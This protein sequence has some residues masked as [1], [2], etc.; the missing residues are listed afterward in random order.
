M[1]GIPLQQQ[2]LL[3]PLK[4]KDLQCRAGCCRQCY[5]FYNRHTILPIE[6]I[7]GPDLDLEKIFNLPR[8]IGYNRS[9]FEEA[10][11][12]LWQD[13]PT[14]QSIMV[15]TPGTYSVEASNNGEC[16]STES[17][18]VAL[19]P[20]VLDLGENIVLVKMRHQLI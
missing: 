7:G 17:I 4:M 9:N 11:S 19:D 8:S 15:N 2:I 12:Y 1:T 16:T 13:N 5:M 14:G 18:E 10:E 20:Y 3:I 6:V